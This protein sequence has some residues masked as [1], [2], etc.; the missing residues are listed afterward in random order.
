[1]KKPAADLP[2]KAGSYKSV[3]SGFSRKQVQSTLAALKALANTRVLDDLSARYGI[4]A[5]KAYG[6]SMANML[7]MAK[8]IGSDHDLAVALWETGWYEARMLATLIDDPD[9]VSAAQ[10]DRWCGDFD[11]WA[12][13]DTACFKL[14]DRV[15]HAWKKVKPWCTK[16][17]EF[18]RRG[19]FALLAC[20]ALHDREG[21]NQPFL[22]GLK[23]VER[24]A[25]DERNFVKK[26]VSWALRSIGRRNAA[27]RSAA[28]EVAE[29]LADSE[30]PASRWVG[31]DALRDLSIR[32]TAVRRK[33]GGRKH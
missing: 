2:A 28:T 23:L 21:G 3:A 31:K 7:K 6:V 20:L 13:C 14:F 11:S 24:G 10:M 33:G 9:Q 27:L 5:K 32:R 12:I 22:E 19:G 1:V 29:R 15:P 16:K 4:F 18:V 8:Q 30:N 25:T 17:D 26:G